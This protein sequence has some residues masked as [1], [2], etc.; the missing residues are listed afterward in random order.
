MARLLED[1]LALRALRAARAEMEKRRDLNAAERMD[2]L[3][4]RTLDI[5]ED[6]LDKTA[7]KL[8]VTR[9]PLFD[10]RESES[11]GLAKPRLVLRSIP[12]LA[13]APTRRR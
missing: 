6:I 9:M 3:V 13:T 8:R 11:P 1:G 2:A 7:E 12:R 4:S 5:E 10:S